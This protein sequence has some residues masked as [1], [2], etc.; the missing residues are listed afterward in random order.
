VTSFQSN[1]EFFQV[2]RD[3]ITKLEVGGHVA[4]AAE[5]EDGFRCLNGLTD[6]WALFLES[7]EKVCT[8]HAKVFAP[9]ERNALESIRAAA[10]KVVYRQ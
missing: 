10:H 5:L 6:G 3:L 7:I 2:V 8:A 4:A 1:E 9:D